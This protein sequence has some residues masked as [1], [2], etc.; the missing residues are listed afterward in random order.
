[1]KKILFILA[2]LVSG[3]VSGQ[4]N[5]T[6]NQVRLNT[7]K[8]ISDSMI[9]VQGS[10]VPGYDSAFNLGNDTNRWDT[11]YADVIDVKAIPS[12]V[13]FSGAGGAL[14]SSI[15]L[16]FDT[17]SG[18][19]NGNA[20]I[21]SY[22]PN[23]SYGGASM[24]QIS[25]GFGDVSFFGGNVIYDD[26]SGNIERID[27]A[28]QGGY[29]YVNSAISNNENGGGGFTMVGPTGTLNKIFQAYQDSIVFY[30]DFRL[31]NTPTASVTDNLLN[32]NSSGEI[33]ATAFSQGVYLPTD[34]LRTNVTTLTLDSAMYT[35][36]GNLVTVSGVLTIDP[37]AGGD[38]SFYLSIPI[39]S[40]MASP[41]VS[42]NIMSG[43]I[44]E[45]GTVLFGTTQKVFVQFVANNTTT[46]MT[47]TF[48]YRIQ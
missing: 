8:A 14:K 20:L 26:G 1:M 5:P 40:N 10:L 31:K 4:T 48:T 44:L 25:A 12:S 13:I 33:T 2:F 37:T 46:S 36:V 23:A 21:L 30:K 35:R 38:L 7:L 32:I 34:S 15:N 27:T 18:A 22:E 11:A 9:N 43:A 17:T 6:F 45:V 19:G 41:F 28:G 3:I 24:S 42:G 39:A 16:Q 29:F 47:Y